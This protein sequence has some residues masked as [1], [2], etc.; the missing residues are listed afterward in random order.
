MEAGEAGEG[1]SNGGEGGHQKLQ[2]GERGRV[3]GHGAGGRGRRRGRRKVEESRGRHGEKRWGGQGYGKWRSVKL[4]KGMEGE[5]CK[6]AI[7]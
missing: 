7:L 1:K 3:R 2:E 5:L 6:G 4:A